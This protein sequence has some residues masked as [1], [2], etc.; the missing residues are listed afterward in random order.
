MWNHLEP[1]VFS[2]LGLRLVYG[3]RAYPKGRHP[4]STILPTI[5]RIGDLELKR[6]LKWRSVSEWRLARLSAFFVGL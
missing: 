4:D 1:A 2:A 5:D 6:A 3:L